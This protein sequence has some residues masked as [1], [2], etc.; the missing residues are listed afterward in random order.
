L[1]SSPSKADK[2]WYTMGEGVGL[3]LVGGEGP[4][5]AVL[6]P[7]LRSVVY[8]VAADSGFDLAGRLDLEP[9]M[10][11][12]DLDS[13]TPSK[14]LREFPKARIRRYPRHKDESDAE[15]GL[16]LFWEMGIER[17]VVAGGGGGRLDH[18]LALVALFEREKRPSAWYTARE[19]VL[20]VEGTHT[21]SECKGQTVSFFPLGGFASRMSSAGLRWPLDGLEWERGDVGLSNV[22]E[23]DRC[24]ISVG[25]G[26]LLMVRTL[27]GDQ[28]ARKNQA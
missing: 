13:I 28:D 1:L 26:R 15:I 18:L 27:V 14:R 12:G 20:V 23:R 2:I 17:A 5:R 24:S 25:R 21:V 8:T 11:V 19:E 22:F 9:D 10:L 3:L 16:R 7:L 6:E 4:H